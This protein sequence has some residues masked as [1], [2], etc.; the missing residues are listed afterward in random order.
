MNSVL[1]R[2]LCLTSLKPCDLA[3]CTK[4]DILDYFENTYDLDETLFSAL[5][6]E[7]SF[8]LCPDQLRLPLIFYFC[9]PSVFYINKLLLS[10]L[11]KEQV[12][13][14]FETLFE[15]GVD[16]M[17]WDDT[18]NCRLGGSFNWPT[19]KECVEYRKKIRYVVRKVIQ[20]TVLEL[21]ITMDSPWWAIFMGFEH[22]RIHL[23]TSSVLIR[24]LPI[25]L[26]QRPLN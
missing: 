14:S 6:G 5:K 13:P 26:V 15:A 17:S 10:G 20:E 8:S 16:E 21:P 9:H 7:S 25:H 18:E 12:E 4:E 23:E 24:Q 1:T 19:L 3:N 22:E 11:I 2:K